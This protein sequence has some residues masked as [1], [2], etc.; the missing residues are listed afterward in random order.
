MFFTI[1][2]SEGRLGR[3]NLFT[4]RAGSSSSRRR[5]GFAKTPIPHYA[6]RLVKHHTWDENDHRVGGF[7]KRAACFGAACMMMFNKGAMPPRKYNGYNNHGTPIHTPRGA[8]MM[9]EDEEDN[10]VGRRYIYDMHHDDGHNMDVYDDNVERKNYCYIYPLA[11]N[12]KEILYCTDKNFRNLMQQNLNTW[13]NKKQ[14]RWKRSYRQWAK[15]IF[16]NICSDCGDDIGCYNRVI[17]PYLK[18]FRKFY[19]DEEE[20]ENIRFDE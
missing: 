15:A 17:L 20:D 9:W 10:S 13:R 2:A 16:K 7:G 1:V 6:K 4:K 5:L 12:C 3:R 11:P 19:P 8:D 18:S 14:E